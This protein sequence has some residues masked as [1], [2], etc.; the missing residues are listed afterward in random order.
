MQA[1]AA[2]DV[3]ASAEAMRAHLLSAAR[4]ANPASGT[5]IVAFVRRRHFAL[6]GA[7][8]LLMERAP[9]ASAEAVVLLGEAARGTPG[10]G[11]AVTT[12]AVPV[13]A[14]AQAV[15]VW[16]LPTR[17]A[18]TPVETISLA[19]VAQLEER[20]VAFLGGGR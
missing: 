12:G 20:L 2:G 11:P 3:A 19:D 9:G 4:R 16:V 8:Y 1:I 5:T 13:A 15:R 18:R 17:Y 14:G 10:S 7:S 6:D